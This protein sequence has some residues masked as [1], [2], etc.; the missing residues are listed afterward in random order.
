MVKKLRCI[1]LSRILK[2]EVNHSVPYKIYRGSLM[3]CL[4]SYF[5]R[6][7]L[8]DKQRNLQILDGTPLPTLDAAHLPHPYEKGK[9]LL[10]LL[11]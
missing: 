3:P 10:M 9:S 6:T 4:I 7:P 2:P 11:V 1:F 5:R 8:V